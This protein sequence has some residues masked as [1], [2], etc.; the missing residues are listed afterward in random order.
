MNASRSA[1]D[2]P[3]SGSPIEPAADPEAQF[4]VAD[5]G[6]EWR[7]GRGI[8]VVPAFDGYR[9]LAIIG[10]VFFHVLLV[11]GV[12]ASLGDSGMGV[13]TWGLLPRAPLTTLFIV[14][15]FVIYLPTVAR[16]GDFGRVASFALRRGARILPAYWVALGIALVLL[17]TVTPSPGVPGAGPIATH[18]ALLETPALLAQS[19]YPLGLGVI[20][21]V[22]TL[23]VELGFYVVLPLVAAA[24]FRHPVVWLAITAGVVVI[25]QE[26][27]LHADG[28]AALFGADLSQ[29]AES[30]IHL[31][32]AS[33]FPSWAFALAAGMTGAWAYV[34]LRDRWPP[35]VLARFALRATAVAALT[36][37]FF[38]YLAGHQ[39]VNDPIPFNGL[40]ARQ[41][42]VVALGYPAALAATLVALTL[43]PGRF[44]SPFA[45]SP[46]RWAADISYGIYLIHFA[47]IWVALRELS[48]PA[49]GSMWAVGAWGALVLPVS[50]AYAYLSA[51]LL[52]RP[53]R[54]WAHRFGRRAQAPDEAPAPA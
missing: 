14:S 22:W 41:S 10:V 38:V 31:Y 2:G 28:I 8:P 45:N 11:S 20:P 13:L 50:I 4:T 6:K 44:Q 24:Y 26:A 54:R 21:P 47:V 40:F 27:A 19:H 33:Q 30:R 3:A 43:L 29:A 37:A 15:G 34:R 1:D 12:F 46:I 18:F 53:V 17:A 35:E 23:S 48:L 39:A 16:D 7:R 49:D 5:P 52:E 25:W 9:A 51:R 42:L 36:L 32:Y